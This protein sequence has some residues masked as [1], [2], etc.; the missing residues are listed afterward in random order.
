MTLD[1][2]IARGATVNREPSKTRQSDKDSCDVNLIMKRYEKTGELPAFANSAFFAD[3]SE[4]GDFRA[5][6]E[7]ILLA[8][9]VFDQLPADVR[10]SFKNDVAEFMDWA[11][12]AENRDGL[13]E[14][15]LIE[16]PEDKPKVE[17]PAQPAS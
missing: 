7:K 17:E 10:L 6:Q 16:K 2:R 12:A 13:V 15:G 11:S 5:V 14:L 4:L 3:V 1:E 9:Q 8:K